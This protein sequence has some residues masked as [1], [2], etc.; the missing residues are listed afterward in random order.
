MEKSKSLKEKGFN[1]NQIKQLMQMDVLIDSMKK[2]SKATDGYFNPLA[3]T[4]VGADNIANAGQRVLTRR[5][6]Q[7][8]EIIAAY[9]GS[10]PL[11]RIIT[12]RARDLVREGLVYSTEMDPK[13]I[14]KLK[15]Q[16]KR[17][18]PKMTEGFK[19]GHLFGGAAGVIITD[20]ADKQKY[21]KEEGTVKNIMELPLNIK[22]INVNSFKGLE[23]RDR[24]YASLTP[25]I[26]L[27]DDTNVP[28]YG[29]P[30]YYYMQ[31]PGKVG[32]TQSTTFASGGVAGS[33]KIHHSWILR[34]EGEV[35]P[36]IERQV[37][38]TW[39]TSILETVL[40]EIN[41]FDAMAN[42]ITDL[43]FRSSLKVIKIENMKDYAN[44]P[45]QEQEVKKRLAE[46][47]K[48]SNNGIMALDEDDQYENIA[49]SFTNLDQILTE[50]K[51]LVAGSGKST[52]GRIF[53]P[54]GGNT[55]VTLESESL[56]YDDIRSEQIEKLQP[57]WDK[58]LP[59]VYKSTFGKELPEDFDY[60]FKYLGDSSEK[61]TYRSLLKDKLD[62]IKENFMFG[63]ITKTIALKELKQ[64]GEEYG[65][66]T[67]ITASYIEEVAEE[68]INEEDYVEEESVEGNNK[69]LNQYSKV[70]MVENDKKD[71]GGIEDKKKTLAVQKDD[72]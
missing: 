15:K 38:N 67:N 39:G 23:I 3:N 16:E 6:Y 52:V 25:S 62:I 21:S 64:V 34:F 31:L 51:L 49:T 32:E 42:I 8:Q 11:Q 36:R 19:W 43:I 20:L 26:E 9:R 7:Y 28:G 70:P 59:I 29:M 69:K 2:V 13:E 56:Y 33:R 24:W 5:S 47:N 71:K 18:K 58:L 72:K 14:H 4:G 57:I 61:T 17:L 60:E 63:L 40:D 50:F 53:G 30:K 54:L 10:W 41:R 68:E 44:N 46:L 1:E 45:E 48:V 55:G 12:T 66:F 27:E 22:D 37:D 65:L 35:M